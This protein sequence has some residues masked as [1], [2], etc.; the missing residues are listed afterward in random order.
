MQTLTQLENLPDRRTCRTY[1]EE[2]RLI[3]GCVL[4]HFKQ[5][6]TAATMRPTAAH[7]DATV[8]AKFLELLTPSDSFI[9]LSTMFS[10]FF[11]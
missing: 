6:M 10:F 1:L 4:R 11:K 8:T 9:L 5:T 3:G 2:C 7:T